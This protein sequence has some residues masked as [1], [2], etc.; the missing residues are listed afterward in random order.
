[1]SLLQLC[2]PVSGQLSSLQICPST[3]LQ[4]R[5]TIRHPRRLVS[6][7]AAP[8]VTAANSPRGTELQECL[9]TGLRGFVSTPFTNVAT[10]IQVRT[11]D[12]TACGLL[13]CASP[14]ADG[15]QLGYEPK[16]E[17]PSTNLF[18]MNGFRRL[19][20]FSYG[21]A[22]SSDS[23]SNLTIAQGKFIYENHGLAG[24]YR[25]AVCR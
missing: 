12:R 1:M 2:N 15:L 18:G 24:L 14:R 16:G 9:G 23:I 19:G 22:R 10:L 5:S 4:M 8:C 6:A 20:L 3:Y 21:T 17:W 7:L 13:C 25:G 11:H